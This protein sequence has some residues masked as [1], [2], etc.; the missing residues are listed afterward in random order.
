MNDLKNIRLVHIYFIL[1]KWLYPLY[2]SDNVEIKSGQVSTASCSTKAL[3]HHQ[4]IN[5]CSNHSSP[6]NKADK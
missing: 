5:P 2:N 6:L 3:N 1:I 4:L